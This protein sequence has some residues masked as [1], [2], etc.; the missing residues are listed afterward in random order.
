MLPKFLFSRYLN[1]KYFKWKEK[2]SFLA[3]EGVVRNVSFMGINIT[4]YVNSK[5]HYKMGRMVDG[6][7]QVVSESSTDLNTSMSASASKIDLSFYDVSPC[8][9]QKAEIVD[10][11]VQETATTSNNNIDIHQSMY[12]FADVNILFDLISLIGKCPK[13]H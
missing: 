5:Q 13:C 10:H 9:S 4:K 1:N 2:N 3:R 11:N 8:S 7:G 12:L 6:D